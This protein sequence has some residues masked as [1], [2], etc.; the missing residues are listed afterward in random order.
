MPDRATVSRVA[1]ILARANSPEPG[2]AAAAL[3]GAYKRMVRDGVRVSDLLSLPLEELYQDAL[4]KLIDVILDAQTGLSPVGRREAYAKYL[5]LIVG[6]FSQEDRDGAGSKAS[7]GSRT[8]ERAAEAERYEESRRAEEAKRGRGG[9][10][11]G[12][13]ASSPRGSRSSGGSKKPFKHENA[14]PDKEI[15]PY[16]FAFDAGRFPIHFAGRDLWAYFFGRGSLLVCLIA[17]PFRG[18]M[19]VLLSCFAGLFLSLIFL[20]VVS[21]VSKSVPA[22]TSPLVAGLAKWD[23]LGVPWFAAF[24]CLGFMIYRHEQGWFFG[25]R[26]GSTFEVVGI[27]L[28]LIRALLWRYYGVF[29]WIANLALLLWANRK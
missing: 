19:L 8:D 10:Q 25:R 7:S 20:L 16:A 11:G 27:A 5:S 24:V 23:I 17:H 15:V 22:L 28:R 26:G 13:G 4:V 29:V 6:R 3:Q 21:A 1:K 18:V 2:E 14:K 9:Q 12:D